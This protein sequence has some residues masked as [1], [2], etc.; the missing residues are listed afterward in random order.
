VL[1]RSQDLLDLA[2]LVIAHRLRMKDART[3][4]QALVREFVMAELARTS[5]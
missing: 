4:P 3:D 2:P 5:Y 1:F